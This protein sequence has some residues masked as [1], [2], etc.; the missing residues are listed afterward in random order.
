MHITLN[1]KI[2]AVGPAERDSKAR[3]LNAFNTLGLLS[4]GTPFLCR[5]KKT[6]DNPPVD[7]C[8]RHMDMDSRKYLVI[9]P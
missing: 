9:S 1:Y 7:I 4:E 6:G 8:V 2:V 3:L 5:T